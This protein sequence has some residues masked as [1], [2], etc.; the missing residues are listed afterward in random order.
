MQ[1]RD[2]IYYLVLWQDVDS[3]NRDLR[4]DEEFPPAQITLEFANPLSSLR[5]YAPTLSA[6]P[7]AEHSFVRAVPV[8]VFDHLTVLEL[9]V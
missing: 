4:R 2:G 8:D 6:Q 9:A 3:Y 5:V 7:V 1:K